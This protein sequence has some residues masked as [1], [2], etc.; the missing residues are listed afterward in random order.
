MEVECFCCIFFFLFGQSLCVLFPF[1]FVYIDEDS[2]DFLFARPEIRHHI[3]C[4][5]IKSSGPIY[6]TLKEFEN[7]SFTLKT[8]QTFSVHTTPEEFEN[9]VFTLKTHQMFSVPTTPREF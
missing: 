3:F 5:H 4:A 6:N 2:Q 9:G 8:H 1:L 7:G